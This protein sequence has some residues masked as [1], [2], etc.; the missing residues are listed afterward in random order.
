VH[1]Q[2]KKTHFCLAWVALAPISIKKSMRACQILFESVVIWK[3]GGRKSCVF[4]V[5]QYTTTAIAWLWT[6]IKPTR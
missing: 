3:N 1:K 5:K 4:G 2:T 6:N